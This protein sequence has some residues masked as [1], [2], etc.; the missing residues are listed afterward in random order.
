MG[1]SGK[2][3][4]TRLPSKPF[5]GEVIR[6]IW[7]EASA[8]VRKAHTRPCTSTRSLTG[9]TKARQAGLDRVWQSRRFEDVTLKGHN[10]ALHGTPELG[11]CSHAGKQKNCTVS[12]RWCGRV[13]GLGI[14]SVRQRRWRSRIPRAPLPPRVRGAGGGSLL[15]MRRRASTRRGVGGPHGRPHPHGPPE[16]HPVRATSKR[17]R[18]AG[19]CDRPRARRG[20]GDRGRA[21]AKEAR[22][23]GSHLT[24]GRNAR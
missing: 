8:H 19:D 9:E 18:R 10:G 24:G 5:A 4:A 13:R 1:T 11:P 21:R 16:V 14:P 2:R 7:N 12:I 15:I 3:G 22:S 23:G 6:T 20:E 17:P